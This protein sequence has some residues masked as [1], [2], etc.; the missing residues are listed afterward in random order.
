MGL[1][2]KFAPME[3]MKRVFAFISKWM[4]VW[5]LLAAVAGMFRPE[6]FSAMGMSAVSPLLGVVM[7]GMGMSLKATDFKVVLMRPKDVLTGC[8]AQFII[9]PGVAWL[10]TKALSLPPDLAVGVILV[11]CCPGG[12]ASNVI[13]FLAGGDL[14]LSVGMT[15]VSTVAAPVLTP[16]L[17]WLLAGEYV[18]VDAAGMLLSILWVVILP[19][20]A[21]LL[22]Q[23]FLPRL[24]CGARDLMPG[25][26]SIVIALI[27]GIIVSRNAESLWCAGHIVVLAVVL[28]NLLGFGLG[29]GVA[30]FLRLPFAK[31]TAMSV[32]VG[33]QNSGLASSLAV[34][35]FASQPMAAVPGAV[36]SVWHN[37]AG[38]VAASVFKR[39]GAKRTERDR[40]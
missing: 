14:A 38:A 3:R 27:V 10:L 17:T 37:I 33:M 9:M 24:T 23:R 2:P 28:H 12:T 8:A 31:C 35:H 20:V 30:W 19:I 39:V 4:G 34:S 16:A 18:D 15:T 36:F 26:S 25:F 13:T 40:L 22:A 5:V 29:F 1:W 11:G 6:A 21:G 32:E 7:F